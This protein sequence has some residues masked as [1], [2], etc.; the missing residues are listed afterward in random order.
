MHMY[1]YLLFVK[2]YYTQHST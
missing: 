1:W 2:M